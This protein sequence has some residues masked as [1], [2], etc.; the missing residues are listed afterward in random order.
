LLD[1]LAGID[2]LVLVPFHHTT[3]LDQTCFG[4]LPVRVKSRRIA[5]WLESAVGPNTHDREDLVTARSR[6]RL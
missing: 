3:L 1:V 6:S 5:L 4:T 2:D